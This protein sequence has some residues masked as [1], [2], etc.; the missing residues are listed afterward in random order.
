MQNWFH[1]VCDVL[2]HYVVCLVQRYNSW[3]CVD[4]TRIWKKASRVSFGSIHMVF[5]FSFCCFF[6]FHCCCSRCCWFACYFSFSLFFLFERFI[7]RLC[8]ID[9]VWFIFIATQC[10]VLVN[11]VVTGMLY[12]VDRWKFVIIHQTQ[13]AR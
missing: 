13:R 5:H 9:F 4:F 10:F 1:A 12:S 6:F 11:K 7:S 3:Q 8:E 2:N